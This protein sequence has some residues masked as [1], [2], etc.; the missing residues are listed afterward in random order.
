MSE[1]AVE[2][3]L[4]PLL[5]SEL[6]R[7]IWKYCLPRRV[8]ELYAP[9][10]ENKLDDCLLPE[11][12]PNPQRPVLTRVSR[13]ARYVVCESG[14]I[15]SRGGHRKNYCGWFDPTTDILHLNWN[16]KTERSS[17][18][19]GY[20]GDGVGIPLKT[21]APLPFFLH[22]TAK[23]TSVSISTYIVGGFDIDTYGHKVTARFFDLL[24]SRKHY[25]VALEMFL[26]HCSLEHAQ[27]SGLFSAEERVKLVSATDTETI[28]KYCSL[29]TERRVR[30]DRPWPDFFLA[31]SEPDIYDQKIRIWRTK[32]ETSWLYHKWQKLKDKTL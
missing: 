1:P 3:H 23:S 10:V 19:E 24:E 16:I 28:S 29:W 9:S 27:A 12:F 13:E 2:F 25:L 30:Q 26:L 7:A 8:V 6:R 17:F 15:L 31:T 14:Y 5:P 18:P 32:I 4:F 20:I 21:D 11:S 22:A